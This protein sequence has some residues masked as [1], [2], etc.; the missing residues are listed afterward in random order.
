[1]RDG[2]VTWPGVQFARC[3]L[4]AH[5]RRA[6]VEQARVLAGWRDIRGHAEVF[7]AAAA[8][9]ALAGLPDPAA[10]VITVAMIPVAVGDAQG[11][12]G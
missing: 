5:S 10:V 11:C 6:A 1:V 2:F 9:W 12:A 7:A 4:T 8:G 3:L